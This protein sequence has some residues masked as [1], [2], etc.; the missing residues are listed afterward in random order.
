[1]RVNTNVSSINAW[2]NLSI[3]DLNMS[4]NLERLSSG[5]RINRAADDAAGLAVS[6][7]M[8]AQIKGIN[9]AIRNSQDGISLVQTAEG[10]MAEIHSM[11]QRMRELAVQ[12]GNDTLQPQDRD[13]IQSEMDHLAKEIT[14]ITNSTQFNAKDLING[15]L[16]NGNISE[17]SLQI[18]PNGGQTVTFGI[19]AMDAKSL[20]ISRDVMTAAIYKENGTVSETGGNFI[21][22]IAATGAVSAGL[23]AGEYTVRFDNTTQTV[24]LFDAAG[25]TA[26]GTAVSATAGATVTIGDVNTARQ[27]TITLQSTLPTAITTDKIYVGSRVATVDDVAAAQEIIDT[28]GVGTGV[29]AVGWGLQSND[30]QVKLT[31]SGG[32]TYAQL[33]DATGTNAIGNA[34]Q[35]G[36]ATTSAGTYTLGDAAT[37]RTLTINVKGGVTASASGQTD[38]VTVVNNG[39]AAENAKFDGGVKYAD[40]QAFAG[41]NVS[42]VSGASAALSIIDAAIAKVSGQRAALG[43]IQN[44]LEHTINNLQVVSENLSASESRIRDV[45]MALEMTQFTKNQILMQAGSAMLAQANAKTQAVLSLLR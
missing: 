34:V 30:Y 23:T 13:Q 12:A 39:Q 25:T 1:M 18:G 6:E 19:D 2:R 20:G 21:A 22:S 45:D 27:V 42:S 29:V 9:Q 11:L 43:A 10:S 32:N 35:V 3:T 38:T 28:T 15:S 41:L 14:R 17:I 40:A 36:A 37:G 16:K 31:N 33:F 8:R 44:R 24:Q 5:M 26:I 4:K 7:K